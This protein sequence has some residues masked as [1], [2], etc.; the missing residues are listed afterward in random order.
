MPVSFTLPMFEGKPASVRD[1][2][3]TVLALKFPLSL[4]EILNEV[5]K[6]YN[7]SV[8]F[9][10]VRKAV[11]ELVHANVLVKEGK[12]F[13]I[14]TQWILNLTKYTGM[15]QRQYFTSPESKTKTKVEV[16]PNV[17]VYTFSRLLDMDFVWNSIIREHFASKPEPPKVITFEAAHYWFVVVTLAQETELM[18]ELHSQDI[19]LY[20]ICRGKSLLDRWTVKHYNE[21]GVH[22]KQ[23]PMPKDFTLGYNIGVYGNLVVYTTHSPETA[24]KMDAFF[25][26]YKKIEEASLAEIFQIVNEPM[27]V[28]LTVINDPVLAKNIRENVMKKWS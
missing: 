6:Q 4:I 9:Q 24:R 23:L 14:N 2:V 22:C 25:K 12:K 26:K 7:V 18:K 8:S 3:F 20:Y 21:V 19:Q 15:L 5:K 17:A 27:S 28:T 16:G 1:K 10:A 13:A 11:L